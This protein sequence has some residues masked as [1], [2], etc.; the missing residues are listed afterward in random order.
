MAPPTLAWSAI[1]LYRLP[2]DGHL[3]G[4]EFALLP[5][6]TMFAANAILHGIIGVPAEPMSGGQCTINEG[7]KAIIIGTRG[8]S[9]RELEG[10][11]DDIADGFRLRQLQD[12]QG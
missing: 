6:G 3:W 1:N 10:Y 8:T 9:A 7:A 12:A 2:S 11:T 4:C 5:A